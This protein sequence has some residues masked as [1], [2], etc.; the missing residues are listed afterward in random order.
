MTG[1]TGVR[2]ELRE[3]WNVG[4][5]SALGR[6]RENTFL[7]G[8]PVDEWG[9]SRS[10]IS[11]GAR[12]MDAE[13]A[14]VCDGTGRSTRSDVSVSKSPSFFIDRMKR[15]RCECGRTFPE[16]STDVITIR[17]GSVRRE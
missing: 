17:F 14:R 15:R 1:V 3:R 4:E 5:A 8:V 9:A 6:R 12:D 7:E 10:V 13:A 2:G 16:E 11:I